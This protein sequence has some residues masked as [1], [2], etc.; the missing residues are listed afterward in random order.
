MKK[1]LKFT[2]LS[3]FIIITICLIFSKSFYNHNKFLQKYF[4]TN[5]AYLTDY[6]DS[7]H[8]ED[9]IDK[10]SDNILGEVRTY[11]VT[12]KLTTIHIEKI[13]YINS[14]LFF[15]I[16]DCDAYYG[17]IYYTYD[18]SISQITPI[19]G[20]DLNIYNSD[21]REVRKNIFVK[22][23]KNHGTDWYKTEKITDNWYYY[24]VHLA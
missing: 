5:A 9:Y 22:G 23:K 7:F 2:A 21:F 17:G 19:Y 12:K 16:K 10:Y 24:E 8:Y 11:S 13:T 18:N 14:Y 20:N 3:L 1:F 4:G 15:E 6:V